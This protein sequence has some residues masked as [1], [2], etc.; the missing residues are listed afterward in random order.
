MIPK[1]LATAIVCLVTLVWIAQQGAQFLVPGFQV[2][3]SV[4]Y[5]F[6]TIV[7]GALLASRKGGGP[8]DPPPTT[9]S[10]TEPEPPPGPPA[11]ERPPGAHRA[12]FSLL[13]RMAAA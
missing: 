10:G 8:P 13:P 11:P 12:G 2:D 7:G 3:G 4:H 9:S 5:I 6:M 1:P